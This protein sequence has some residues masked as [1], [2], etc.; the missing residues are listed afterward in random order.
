MP[1]SPVRRLLDFDAQYRRD[2]QHTPVFLHRR[3]RRLALAREQDGAPPPD[4]AAWLSAVDAPDAGA[5]LRTW[6]R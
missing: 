1:L 2:Q 6:R 4:A 5:A 3:A